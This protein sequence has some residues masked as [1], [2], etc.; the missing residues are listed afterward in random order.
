[1]YNFILVN[2]FFEVDFLLKLFF[3]SMSS[4]DK[5]FILSF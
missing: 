5:K 2:R 1:M 3:N 4:G